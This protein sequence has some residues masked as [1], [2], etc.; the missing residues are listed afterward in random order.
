VTEDAAAAYAAR[1]QA[2]LDRL[3]DNDPA[4]AFDGFRWAL[5]YAGPAPVERERLADALGVLARITVAMGHREVAELCARASTDV[6]DPDALFALGYELIEVGLPAIAATVLRRCLDVVPGSEQVVIELVAALERVLRYGDAADVLRA[7]GKLVDDSFACRYHLA[8]DAV[9]SGALDEARLIAARLGD[10]AATSDDERFMAARIGA[11]LA[12][13]DRVAAVTPLDATDLRGWHYVVTGG[14]LLHRSPH[15]FDAGMRGR[16]AW[17]Q[18]S[19]ALLMTGALRLRELLAGWSV[20]PPVVYAL[21]G[22]DHERVAE[23]VARVLGV[24]RAPWPALGVPAPGIVAAYDLA[25]VPWRDLE[26]LVE[27]RDGQLLFAHASRWVEDGPVAPDVT[28]LLHQSVIPPWGARL[29]VDAA[30][31][32]RRAEADERDADMLAAEIVTTPPIEGDDLVHDDL[33]GLAALAAAIGAPTVGRR[34]RLW[35]GSPVI[36]SRF[37]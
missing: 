5:W 36:S 4:G 16:Y 37:E 2:A 14:V 9:M 28:T 21:P 18:D 11:L 10:D 23:V 24:P 3:S 8:F 15:G 33:P 32:T 25:D 34:E 22:P 7:H 13:A 17:L 30:G 12:R 1:R 27:R 29:V 31:A 20:A 35:G 26:R 6:D 19:R